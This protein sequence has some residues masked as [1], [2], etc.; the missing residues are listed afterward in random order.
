MKSFVLVNEIT[1][2]FCHKLRAILMAR[3]IS[4]QSCRSMEVMSVVASCDSSILNLLRWR[5]AALQE[6][7]RV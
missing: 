3:I 1:M 7:A 6:L 5:C 2:I 4:R